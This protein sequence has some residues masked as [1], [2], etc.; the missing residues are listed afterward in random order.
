MRR[1]LPVIIWMFGLYLVTTLTAGFDIE[2]SN[3][4]QVIWNEVQHVVIHVFGYAVQVW[5]IAH[6]LGPATRS[7]RGRTAAVLI[8]LGLVLGIGQEVLQTLVRAELR[9]LPSIFDLVTDT[10]GAWL[11]LRIYNRGQGGS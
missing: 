1:H 5:L 11:G 2:P 4:L 8:G 10:A 6:A 9:L 3:L 7:N